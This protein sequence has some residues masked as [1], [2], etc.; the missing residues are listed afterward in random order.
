[1]R[2]SV[3]LVEVFLLAVAAFLGLHDLPLRGRA[4]GLGRETLVSLYVML[5]NG[6]VI[7][8]YGRFTGNSD[9]YKLP[10]RPTR[11]NPRPRLLGS[12]TP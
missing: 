11:L 4:R 6:A 7:M 9:Y 10:R 5:A 3:I 2:V 8:L 1:M 12:K